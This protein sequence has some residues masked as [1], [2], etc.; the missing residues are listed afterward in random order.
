LPT[1]RPA[2]LFSVKDRAARMHVH[3]L[4]NVS[5]LD[6][7][8]V[9]E[10]HLSVKVRSLRSRSGFTFSPNLA[11]LPP[12]AMAI[13]PGEPHRQK[14]REHPAAMCAPTYRDRPQPGPSIH[15]ERNTDASKKSGASPRNKQ[16][17]LS[18]LRRSQSKVWLREWQ[19]AIS[20]SAVPSALLCLARSAMG[21][22]RA[23][24]L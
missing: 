13:T 16:S 17:A 18:A 8:A 6:A 19:A 11:D 9:A 23:R 10:S 21:R 2:A 3:S 15:P 4:L 22:P 12:P 14:S 1:R 7:A 20:M 24:R 5:L